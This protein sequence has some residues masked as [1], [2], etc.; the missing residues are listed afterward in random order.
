MN[1][2]LGYNRVYGYFIGYNRVY[3]LTVN[4]VKTVKHGYNRVLKYNVNAVP[5][6]IV[7]STGPINKYCITQLEWEPFDLV[8]ETI[9]ELFGTVNTA[10]CHVVHA[11]SA[12]GER[13]AA[14]Q[15]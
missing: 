2:I 1:H 8:C 12:G 3:C 4:T 7:I 11:T 9:S 13:V 5:L 15:S 14:K 6:L 10:E